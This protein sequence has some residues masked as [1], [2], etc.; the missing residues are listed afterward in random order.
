MDMNQRQTALALA[1]VVELSKRI[2]VRVIG[3]D[4]STKVDGE[5]VAENAEV[6]LT[7]RMNERLTTKIR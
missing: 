6:L 3:N 4:L 5:D 1:N 2:L 7:S